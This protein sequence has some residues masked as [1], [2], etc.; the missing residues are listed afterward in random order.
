L[1]L[2]PISCP[3]IIIGDFN[4]NMFDQN[5]TQPNELQRFMD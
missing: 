4:I 2:M 3:I 5:W 1:D